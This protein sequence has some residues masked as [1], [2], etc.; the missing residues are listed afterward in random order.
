MSTPWFISHNALLYVLYEGQG[1]LCEILLA[2]FCGAAVKL[3]GQHKVD[4]VLLHYIH[5]IHN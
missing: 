1:Y 5:C 2:D 4:S 3:L